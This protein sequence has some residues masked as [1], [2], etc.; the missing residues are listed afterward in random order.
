MRNDLEQVKILA[1]SWNAEQVL[2]WAFATYGDDVA[3]ATGMGVEGMVLV[4]IASRINPD[5]KVFTGDTEFL[6]VTI[7]PNQLR[8]LIDARLVGEHTRLRHGKGAAARWITADGD[9]V[10]HE[11]HLAGRFPPVG[12]EALRHQPVIQHEEEKAFG[13]RR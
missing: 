3:I 13:V 1:E 2:S 9:L 8:H 4:D 10:G 7:E 5:M 6:P 11:H 12:I